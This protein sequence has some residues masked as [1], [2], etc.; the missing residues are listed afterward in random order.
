[1]INKYNIPWL[2]TIAIHSKN[3]P[4]SCVAI[5][6]EKKELKNRVPN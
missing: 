3:L 6:S 4:Y 5:Y 1:M 2:F